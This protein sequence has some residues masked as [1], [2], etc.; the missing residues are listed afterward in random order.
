MDKLGKIH[1]SKLRTSLEGLKVCSLM[2]LTA[3]HGVTPR[4]DKRRKKDL[5]TA[6]SQCPDFISAVT[7]DAMDTSGDADQPTTQEMSSAG[8]AA[9]VA[10]MDTSA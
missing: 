3:R 8:D 6:L 10:A 1:A 7:G 5:A 9:A 4:H 2:S